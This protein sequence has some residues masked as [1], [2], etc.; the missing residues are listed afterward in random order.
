M[1]RGEANR[2]SHRNCRQQLISLATQ[3]EGKIF[4][5]CRRENRERKGCCSLET[6]NNEKVSRLGILPRVMRSDE[7]IYSTWKRK[8]ILEI[9]NL[10]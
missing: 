1:Y 7:N 9:R 10:H 8:M 4:A 6:R 3:I 2:L 5:F